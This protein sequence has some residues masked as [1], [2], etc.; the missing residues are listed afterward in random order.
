MRASF[1]AQLAGGIQHAVE[2]AA[3]TKIK[4][5][6]ITARGR[7]GGGNDNNRRSGFGFWGWFS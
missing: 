1:V 2:M 7:R 6:G 4:A 3:I 5:D